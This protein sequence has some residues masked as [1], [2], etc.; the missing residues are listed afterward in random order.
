MLRIDNYAMDMIP[1]G[2][3]VVIQND[4]MPGM[5]GIVGTSFG[6]AKVNIADMVISR[7]YDKAGKATAFQVIKTDSSPD[8]KL[9]ESLK[10]RPGILKVKSVALPARG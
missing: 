5:I 1:E 9:L 7:E 10:A 4:D 6:D 8:A 2:N 3:M